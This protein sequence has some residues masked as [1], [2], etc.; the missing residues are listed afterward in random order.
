[1]FLPAQILFFV[2]PDTVQAYVDVQEKN[3]IPQFC[4]PLV[5]WIK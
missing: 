1:M 2:V 3:C 4:I 5:F